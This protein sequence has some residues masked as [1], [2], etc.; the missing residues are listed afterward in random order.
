EMDHNRPYPGQDHTL[1]TSYVGFFLFANKNDDP[2]G[3]YTTTIAIPNLTTTGM[4]GSCLKFW[5]ISNQASVKDV[6]KFGAYFQVSLLQ[7]N[8]KSNEVVTWREVY[9]LHNKWTHAQATIIANFPHKV[10][11]T[12]TKE[13]N[14][15]M[16]AYIALDDVSLSDGA[17]EM[18]IGCDF[19]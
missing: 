2:P 8:G 14:K 7:Q 6:N 16:K 19:D 3:K 15:D 17:C 12:F 10:V 18:P 1:T 9:P 5:Y 4:R 11:F 13:A